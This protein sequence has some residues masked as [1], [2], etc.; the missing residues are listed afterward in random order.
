MTDKHDDKGNGYSDESSVVHNDEARRGGYGDT[1]VFGHEEGHD[2]KYKT[3]SW[4]LVAVLMIAEIVS[5]GML[6]LPSSLAV[7]GIVPGLIIIIFLGVF[8]TYTSW[9][10]VKFKMNHPEVHN[11]GDAGYILFGPVGRELLAFGTVV[12]AVFATGGQLLAGQIALAA[13]SD[14]KLCL[15]LYTGIFA[16][17]TLICSFPRTLDGL[18]WLSIPSVLSI[19]VAGIVGMVGAG[20]HPEPGRTVSVAESSSFYTAFISITN[21]V[22]AYAGHF[23]FFIMVSEMKKPQHAMRAAYTL[24]SFATTYYA[25][26]AAV[27]YVYIGNSVAS[28]AFSSL[29][30]KWQKAAYGIAIP[31]FL[32]AGSLYAHTASKLVFVRL[33]RHSRHLHSHTVLGWGTWAI[34][35]LIMNGC[36]FVLAVGVPIFNYLIGIAASL[37]AAWFTYGIAGMF[38]LHDAYH[39]EDGFSTWTR[40]WFQSTLALVTV[41]IGAFICVAGMYVTVRSI[42]EAYDTGEVAS[43]FA[44]RRQYQ[45]ANEVVLSNS[46]SSPATMPMSTAQHLSPS[47][48]ATLA[49]NNQGRR[50][51]FADDYAPSVL[52]LRL[53]LGPRQRPT[54]VLKISIYFEH[55]RLPRV[56]VKTKKPRERRRRQYVPEEE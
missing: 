25:V 9:L 53:K 47:S 3:L 15:M 50:V 7:V 13:L 8:A 14:N 39:I 40:K 34:L 32:I 38:W 21:P 35:I 36:A 4:Q 30:P 44:S 37:F 24:Q 52:S 55:G 54:M 10:L 51:R 12:F 26:F 43:P 16:I 6:S 28:P 27:V 2:I 31:N 23:M 5:N 19:M 17:P 49:S 20:T 33:F 45:E 1:D 42:V 56:K 22:F 11:M 48:P 18:S 46:T 41:V 29:E